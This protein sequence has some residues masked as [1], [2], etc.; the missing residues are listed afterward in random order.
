MQL[1]WHLLSSVHLSLDLLLALLSIPMSR[2]LFGSFQS[3]Q[4]SE[5]GDDVE[6]LISFL[7]LLKIK[8][9]VTSSLTPRA[10][11]PPARRSLR[12]AWNGNTP[13]NKA[14]RA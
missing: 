9:L 5:R 7:Q 3:F 14:R 4:G 11:K 1:A 13:W 8:L 6:V 12:W 10:K 2:V